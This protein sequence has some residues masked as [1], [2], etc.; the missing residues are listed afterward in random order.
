MKAQDGCGTD[1]TAPI[2]E[3]GGGF[4]DPD[5]NKEVETAAIKEVTRLLVGQGYSVESRE[6]ENLGYDLDAKRSGDTLHAE[7]KGAAGCAPN[8]F[9][10]PGELKC[11]T[12]DPSFR[13]FVVTNALGSPSTISFTGNQLLE[14]YSLTPQC[15]KATLKK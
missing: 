14:K 7:V 1:F 15:Y 12:T 4:G 6:T 11:A 8:F 10:T 2:Q 5:S 9:I 3:L 13:L